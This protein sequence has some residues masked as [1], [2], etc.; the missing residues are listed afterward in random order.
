[1][2]SAITNLSISCMLQV[3]RFTCHSNIHGDLI[4]TGKITDYKI[5]SISQHSYMALVLQHVF[6]ILKFRIRQRR[7]HQILCNDGRFGSWKSKFRSWKSVFKR[8]TNVTDRVRTSY[9]IPQANTSLIYW[10]TAKSRC[11]PP[12]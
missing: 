5:P 3:E 8:R 4:N 11:G 7:R 1:M 9:K 6:S 12:S 10:R 2:I